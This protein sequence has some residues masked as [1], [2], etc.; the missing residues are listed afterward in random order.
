MTNSQL[1]D[2]LAW[3]HFED[4]QLLMTLSK[5]K[6]TYYIPGGKREGSESDEEA[7][8]R[9]VKEELTVDL[10]KSTIK[11]YGTFEA[12]AHGKPIGTIVRMTCYFADYSGKLQP[13]MEI[14]NIDYY[15]YA[16][17]DIVGPVDQIIFDDLYEKGLLK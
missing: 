17:R 5:G 3:L 11:H 9:E 6:D 10:N 12:Q 8:V 15:T 13:S 4:K 16:Q 1:I 7:L 2:K 14:Q